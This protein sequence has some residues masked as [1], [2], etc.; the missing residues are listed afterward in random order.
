MLLL[1]I[2]AEERPVAEGGCLP[3]LALALDEEGLSLG[4]DGFG[5][6]CGQAPAFGAWARSSGAVG[7]SPR[8][9]D[10]GAPEVPPFCPHCY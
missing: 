4:V 2:L 6:V 9:G 3:L 5:K 10:A 1:C 8:H 7:Q